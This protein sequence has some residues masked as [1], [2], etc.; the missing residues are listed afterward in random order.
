MQAEN[1]THESRNTLKAKILHTAMQSFVTEGIKPV[2]MD[3]IARKLVIS[4]RTLYEIFADKE[5]LLLEGVVHYQKMTKQKMTQVAKDSKNVLETILLIYEKK[6]EELRYITPRFYQDL[7]KYSSVMEY[8]KKRNEAETAE[9]VAFL[10]KGVGQGFFR[11][12][13]NFTVINQFLNDQADYI[14]N[15]DSLKEI[16]I[17]EIFDSMIL[18]YIRGFS[19]DKG[20]K[21]IENFLKERK[22]TP[23]S[24]QHK[25][26]FKWE[27]LNIEDNC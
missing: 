18:V 1:S 7:R 6:M 8:I 15:R 5:Q 12:D 16:P 24:E 19:T 9:A 13:V 14:I 17:T 25:L 20:L 23:L 27:D 22:N 2:T 11:N 3:M 10:E 4:K 21:I 26:S